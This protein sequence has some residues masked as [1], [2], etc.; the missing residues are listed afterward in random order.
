MDEGM[1]SCARYFFEN[2]IQPYRVKYH[3]MRSRYE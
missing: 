2:L 1:L 3:M